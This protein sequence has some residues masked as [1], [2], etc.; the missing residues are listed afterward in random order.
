LTFGLLW[1][2]RA[3]HTAGSGTVSALRLI[4]PKGQSAIL[5]HRLA[6]SDPHV[7]IQIFDAPVAAFG[8]ILNCLYATVRYDRAVTLL[9]D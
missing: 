7:T 5:A 6:A 1:L 2:Q 9:P 4:L 3:R 8:N